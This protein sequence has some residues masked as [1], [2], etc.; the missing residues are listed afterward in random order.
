M[1]RAKSSC[2]RAADPPTA[3]RTI[4]PTQTRPKKKRRQ[5]HH[6]LHENEF[7]L[8]W[9]RSGE[10]ADGDVVTGDVLEPTWQELSHIDLGV[11][12]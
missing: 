5:R 7:F 12:E 11:E 8:G 4:F 9:V 1:A 3:H 6:L 10:D 2:E